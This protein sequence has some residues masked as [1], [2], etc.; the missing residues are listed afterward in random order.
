MGS[1]AHSAT[2]KSKENFV[3]GGCFWFKNHD[4]N[5]LRQVGTKIKCFKG[6]LIG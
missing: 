3:F 4:K 5:H 2:C 6:D 1:D